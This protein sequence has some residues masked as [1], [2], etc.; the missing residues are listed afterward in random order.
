[1][2][3]RSEITG[4]L[5]RRMVEVAR[6]LRKEST[7]GEDLLWQQLRRG[8]LLARFRRQHVI[9]PFVVDFYCAACRLIV[10]VDGGV[11]DD[12]GVRSADEE[13][14]ALLEQLG[15]HF[16]RVRTELVEAD[17]NAAVAMVRAAM[18]Q[19]PGVS[20]AR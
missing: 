17:T 16:C 2:R 11:H 19:L 1:M 14:Q 6:V 5:R 15:Y 12:P 20:R 18:A 7:R 10:E 9:G 3:E 8:R 13:R 4:E